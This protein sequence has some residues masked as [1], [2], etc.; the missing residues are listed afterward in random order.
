MREHLKATAKI[1]H[2]PAFETVVVNVKYSNLERM[3][4]PVFDISQ[5]ALSDRNLVLS[6]N[7][8]KRIGGHK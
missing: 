6:G 1:V 3:N 2:R 7:E 8:S 5:L 4:V